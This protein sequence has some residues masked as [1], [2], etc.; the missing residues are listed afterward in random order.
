[1]ASAMTMGTLQL[2][3]E[4]VSL[5]SGRRAWITCAATIAEPH[6]VLMIVLAYRIMKGIGVTRGTENNSKT[7][8]NVATVDTFDISVHPT[9]VQL[10][11]K[12]VLNAYNLSRT[13]SRS[14]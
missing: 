12:H 4:N 13:H 8:D 6:S 5:G 1:M 14:Y 7:N 3:S 2:P 11:A 9:I 10:P